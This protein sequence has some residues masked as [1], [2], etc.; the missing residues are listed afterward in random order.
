MTNKEIQDYI[1]LMNQIKVDFPIFKGQISKK[2]EIVI[3]WSG[4]FINNKSIVSDYEPCRFFIIKN[5]LH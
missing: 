5:D 3:I 4:D 1:N 2:V